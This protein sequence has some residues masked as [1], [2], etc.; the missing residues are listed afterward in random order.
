LAVFVFH[1][2]SICSSLSSI[3]RCRFFLFYKLFIIH[4]SISIFTH[5]PFTNFKKIIYAEETDL[6]LIHIFEKGL[7]K[8]TKFFRVKHILESR[9]KFRKNRFFHKRSRDGELILVPDPK[10]KT[11]IL[12]LAD[13]S[14]NGYEDY[15]NS[16]NWKEIPGFN[17]VRFLNFLI[18]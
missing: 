15:R 9:R 4:Y 12:N 17:L 7:H 18:F 8:N 16:T 1:C 13:M 2:L 14:S 10:D 3:H 6:E 11:T 5:V